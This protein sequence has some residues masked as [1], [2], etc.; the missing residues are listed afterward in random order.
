M[1]ICI[2]GDGAW[3]K[4]LA[5][6]ARGGG[7]DVHIWSR[8]NPRIVQV[9]AFIVAVPAQAVRAVLQQV[10]V[11]SAPVIIAAKG[12]ERGSNLL[13]AQVLRAVAPGATP[14]VLSGPSFA[15]DVV[16]GLPTAVTLAADDL[17]LAQQWAQALS[18][19]MFRIYSTDDI[20]GVE[21]GGA[22]KNVLAIAC[23]ISD[24]L[25]FGDSARAAL[26]TRG[27]AE[28]SRLAVAMGA[29]A[30]TIMGLSGLGDLMLTASSTQSRNFAFGFKL[31]R[32]KC[33]ADALGAS[34]GVV[35]GAA[36]AVAAVALSKHYKIDMPIT[37][38]V[39]QIVDDGAKVVDVVTALLQRPARIE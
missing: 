11:G 6:V 9:D 4:A 13:M 33:V 16:K 15:A 7:H 18:Q 20:A 35:E 39:H 37:H 27:F 32:G 10:D 23:G 2:L 1:R 25:G 21:L 38:G 5:H 19:P 34:T 8:A 31:G 17:V 14:L 28:L 22:L 24:G 26:M 29:R 36:T 30:P 3:G 12:I